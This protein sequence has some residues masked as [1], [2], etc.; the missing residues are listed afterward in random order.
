ML[1]CY[2]LLDAEGVFLCEKVN[3]NNK[4]LFS[5]LTA[6][7]FKTKLVPG[8]QA[9]KMSEFWGSLHPSQLTRNIQLQED[10]FSSDK[11]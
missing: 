10:D 6:T 4:S 3:V 7:S 11:P 8:N 2:Q 5:S 1:C 9:Q